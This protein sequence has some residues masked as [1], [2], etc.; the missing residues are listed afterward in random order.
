MQREI[1][2]AT[3]FAIALAV[4]K[5]LDEITPDELLLGCLRSLS[6][7]G[8]ARLGPWVFD[9]EAFGIDWLASPA[10]GAATKV[11][12]SEGTVEIFDRA[13]RIARAENSGPMRLEH[14]LAAFAGRE[15]GL[16]AKLAR[17]HGITSASW[18]SALVELPSTGAVEPVSAPTGY[19]TP[20]AAAEALGIHVQTLR[21]YIRSGKLPARRSRNPARTIAGLIEK[22]KQPMPTFVAKRDLPGITPDALQS[23][24]VRA[25]TCCSQMT[26][27]GEPVRWIRSFFLPATSQTHCYFEAASQE[28][29]AEANNR[30][31]IPFT[32]IVE[33]VE[34]TPDSV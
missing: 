29:V 13:A 7:F 30:A 23:A 21:G 5:G 28:A 1:E 10:P 26:G 19:L 20:E 9:L 32:E 8:I 6:H 31:R 27:E 12:Y 24:G 14:L 25:K 18:R 2:T 4:E 11:S 16:M 15:T 22:E 34:M 3:A 17:T 33:V